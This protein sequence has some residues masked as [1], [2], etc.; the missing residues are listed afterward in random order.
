MMVIQE[1][2]HLPDS[3]SS[4]QFIRLYEISSVL[5]SNPVSPFQPFRAVGKGEWTVTG[6][7]DLD[8]SMSWRGQRRWK[9]L[10]R[11]KMRLVGIGRTFSHWKKHPECVFTWADLIS[12]KWFWERCWF[13]TILTL[14]A[15][16]CSNKEMLLQK[17]ARGF[18]D[19]F[20]VV[21]SSGSLRK[22]SA[23]CLQSIPVVGVDLAYYQKALTL[24]WSCSCLFSLFLDNFSAVQSWFGWGYWRECCADFWLKYGEGL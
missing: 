23:P 3:P 12:K 15:G 17:I 2:N 14:C 21:D 7:V 24:A 8:D 18:L 13:G 1:T 5:H 4:R 19:P 22:C 6:P 11:L 20:D 9:K 10:M 16:P